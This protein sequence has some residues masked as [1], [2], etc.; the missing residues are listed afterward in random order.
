MMRSSSGPQF[1]R[2]RQLWDEKAEIPGVQRSDL[3]VNVNDH[4]DDKRAYEGEL[5]RMKR[6]NEFIKDQLQRSFREL[7]A[8]QIKYPSAYSPTEV[9][10][11]LPPWITDPKLMNPVI[12]AYDSSKCG[13][14]QRLRN[15]I[16]C[17]DSRIIYE[18]VMYHIT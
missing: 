16:S 8:F 13:L 12:T 4:N 5:L 1:E 17:H 14:L 10:D 7:K 6:E 18:V 3:V 9:E 15:I 2:N 11:N